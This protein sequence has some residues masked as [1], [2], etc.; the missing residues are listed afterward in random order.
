[1]KLNNETITKL[2]GLPKSPEGHWDLNH[3]KIVLDLIDY[4][5]KSMLEIGFN[6]GFSATVFLD[7]LNIENFYS[8]DIGLHNFV[9]PTQNKFKELY[10][11]RFHPYIEDSLKI[12]DTELNDM[13]FDLVFIDGG[14]K[15]PVALNDWLFAID[16]CNYILLD[17]TGG[18]SPG[19]IDLIKIINHGNENMKPMI[20]EK[21]ELIKDFKVGAGAQLYK[22]KK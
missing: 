13:K 22:V 21:V 18:A 1:M 17:D 10:G 16:R 4:D 9:E 7:V 12:R 14:H 3:A 20:G 8:L 5:I 2:N 15:L 11:D 6:T 19:V